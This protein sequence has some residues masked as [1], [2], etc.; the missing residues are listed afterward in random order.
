MEQL[1][2]IPDKSTRNRSLDLMKGIAMLF[3]LFAHHGSVPGATHLVYYFQPYAY[4]IS[5][6]LFASGFL[7]HDLRSWEDYRRFLRAKTLHLALPLLGWNVVY[8]VI[9]TVIPYFTGIR[10]TRTPEQIWTIESLLF[11]PFLGG[12]QY[13]FNLATWFVG[14]LYVTLVVYGLFQ[15][16]HS[17]LE[18]R[19]HRS[20]PHWLTLPFYFGLAVSALYLTNLP[21][22]SHWVLG[23]L[24]LLFA[25]FIIHVGRCYALYLDGHI[26]PRLQFPLM[27]VVFALFRLVLHFGGGTC[28]IAWMN[29]GGE[30]FLPLFVCVLGPVLW[31]LFSDIM[32]RHL[33]GGILENYVGRYT[34]S[35]MTNHLLVRFAICAWCTYLLHDAAALEEFRSS[36]WFIPSNADFWLLIIAELT[37]CILWQI[38]FDKLK[39]LFRVHPMLL[40]KTLWG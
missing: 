7:L 6:F 40:T 1:T 31:K 23:G 38:A 15:V 29:F 35:I 34:W 22:T 11:E 16:L 32:V 30:H 21:F 3:V 18:E 13:T 19:C 24:K 39:K 9:A 28:G 20:V 4:C 27:I 17:R 10:F 26:R 12:H 37:L 2:P 8:A 33:P 14:T 25:L 36:I 5:M